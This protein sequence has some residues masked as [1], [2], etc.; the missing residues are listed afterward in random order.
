LD[1]ESIVNN[2]QR[3]NVLA[4]QRRY[5]EAI[6]AFC[7]HA[8]EVPSEAAKAWT[9]AGECSEFANVLPGP[10]AVADGAMTLLS[11]GDRR[12]AE[13]FF[14]RALTSDPDYP[15]ALRGLAKTLPDT[16]DERREV[17]ERALAVSPDLLTILE[18]GDFHRTVRRDYA[19][20]QE[21]YE[22]AVAHTPQ[23][24]SA[25]LKL[26]DLCRRSGRPDEA[27]SWST[28]LKERAKVGTPTPNS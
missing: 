28:R 27:A 11:Q 7:T 17:L 1:V 16:A 4:N 9:R 24:K 23:D 8:R 25:Y 13:Q 19:K 5:E 10:V 14:R 18:L 22:R 2:Y 26:I 15:R 6:D 12:G 21:L 20:A 3:G